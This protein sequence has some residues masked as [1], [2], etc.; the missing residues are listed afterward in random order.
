VATCSG[1][2]ASGAS[3]DTSS[4]GSK[5]FAVNAT[6][7]AGNSSSASAPYVVAYNICPLY[8]QTMA[9]QSGAVIPIKLA[10]CDANGND[11]STSA[12]TVH[13]TGVVQVSTNAP[14]MLESVG[15]ANPDN[16]FRFDSTVGTSGG[17]IFNLSTQ[18]LAT[19]AYQL[20]FTVT[21]DPNPAQRP[22]PGPPV[23]AAG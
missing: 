6:D 5:P 9:V 23:K 10:L 16:H 8:D 15:N 19:G 20:S 22:A 7:K 18:G 4:V 1:P 3:L 21:G 2:V 12:I 13:A 11:V 14:G 17:Y